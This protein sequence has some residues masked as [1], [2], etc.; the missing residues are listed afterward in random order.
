MELTSP[1][2]LVLCESSY[3]IL[4]GIGTNPP[5]HLIRLD[6]GPLD[7]EDGWTFVRSRL[8]KAAGECPITDA[9]TVSHFMEKR[10]A[11]HGMMSIDELHRTC[12]AVFEEA[13]RRLSPRVTLDDFQDYYLRL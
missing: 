12:V 13:V 8:E 11:R 9:Q 6:V 7:V 2:L 4:S 1:Q 5:G 10:I 3:D